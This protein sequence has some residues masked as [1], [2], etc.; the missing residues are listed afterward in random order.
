VENRPCGGIGCNMNPNQD[1]FG[2][3]PD[4][5]FPEEVDNI[6]DYMRDNFSTNMNPYSQENSSSD[7]GSPLIDRDTDGLIKVQPIQDNNDSKMSNTEINHLV[8]YNS[9]NQ[10]GRQGEGQK[11]NNSEDS[12]N[13]SKSQDS[14][15]NENSNSNSNSF[16]RLRRSR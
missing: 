10:G 3:Y 2:F 13:Q 5:V 14:Q 9:E 1:M 16:R 7:S 8:R 11:Q 4:K 12:Q 15:P 6:K